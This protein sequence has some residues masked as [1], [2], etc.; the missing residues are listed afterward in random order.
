MTI[1]P[2][3]FEGVGGGIFSRIKWVKVSLA[4]D[5]IGNQ[6]CHTD[7]TRNDTEL[8]KYVVKDLEN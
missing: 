1:S 5:S 2:S 4:I 7:L 3:D 8:L 6:N